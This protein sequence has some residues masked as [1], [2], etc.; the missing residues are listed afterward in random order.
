MPGNFEKLGTKQDPS[1]PSFLA[2]DSDAI[3]TSI[4][5][6]IN[7]VR[8]LAEVDHFIHEFGETVVPFDAEAAKVWGEYVSRP[9]LKQKPRSYPDTQI[10]AMPALQ[11]SD[12]SHDSH[13]LRLR[14]PAGGTFI[15][16]GQIG[17]Q[18]ASQQNGGQF[19]GPERVT[20]PQAGNFTRVSGQVGFNPVCTRHRP[21]GWPSGTA[22]HN[23]L[24]DFAS[25]VDASKKLPQQIK[26][27]DSGER[28]ERGGIRNDNH[29]LRRSAVTP[30]SARSVAV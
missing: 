12:A 27:A 25:N 28:D 16:D 1:N 2:S 5:S 8:L 30:S 14:Q 26:P 23:F 19:S 13:A 6:T 7:R 29:S 9:A 10:A 20:C 15:N 11:N 4:Q 17:S 22:N 21:G 3:V 24:V 18:R